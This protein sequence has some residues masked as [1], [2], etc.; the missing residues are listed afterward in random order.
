MPIS[1]PSLVARIIMKR[2]S[3]Q[4]DQIAQLSFEECYDVSDETPLELC[5]P[6]DIFTGLA[7]LEIESAVVDYETP[8]AAILKAHT[9]SVNPVELESTPF[10]RPRTKY[11]S[12]AHCNN[13]RRNKSPPNFL[14]R[15]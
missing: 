1:R 6:N 5:H 4:A 14:S 3:Q 13:H 10:P 8:L 12:I 11:M 2:I 15:K 9:A 7:Q